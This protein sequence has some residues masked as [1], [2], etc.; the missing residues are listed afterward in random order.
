MEMPVVCGLSD[1]VHLFRSYISYIAYVRK[2]SNIYFIIY[3][4]LQQSSTVTV[5]KGLK[6]NEWK[7]KYDSSKLY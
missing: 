6:Q 3:L 4:V 7:V 2:V 5:I 1:Y